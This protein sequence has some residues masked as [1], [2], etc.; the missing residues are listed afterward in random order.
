MRSIKVLLFPAL[1]FLLV[2]GIQAA[3]ADAPTEYQLYFL[4][5]QSNM[6]GFGT[7]SELSG[8][9]LGD[10]DRVMIFTGRMVSDNESGGG[11]GTWDVLRPG[12]GTGF[13]TD[14]EGNTLS[15]RFGPELSFGKQLAELQPSAKIA[16][17]NCSMTS[18]WPMMIL[19]SSA[20]TAL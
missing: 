1:V 6:E 5:G 12:H 9:W 19:P 11:V 2:A 3:M 10:V 14:G 8:E 7:N 18:F 13:I 17:I 15:G 4:G 16:I 20:R